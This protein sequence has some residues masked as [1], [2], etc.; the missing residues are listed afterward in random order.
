MTVLRYRSDEATIYP[1]HMK[2]LPVVAF[3]FD[4]VIADNTWPSPELGQ[5]PKEDAVNAMRHYYDLG[6]EIHIL[7]ARPDSHF[8][9]IWR[10]LETHEL[11]YLVY[12]VTSTKMP[13]GL[14]F[15]DRAVR[16]PL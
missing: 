15:D 8:Q 7:T 11:D 2:D 14:Y 4:G 5:W 12:D 16:W 10:W 9:R 6:C 13:A 3:D 1:E